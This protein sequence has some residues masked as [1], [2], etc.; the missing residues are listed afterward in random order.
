[1]VILLSGWS[2]QWGRGGDG[3]LAERNGQL[4]GDAGEMVILL[5]GWSAQWGRGGDGDLAE[6]MVSSVGTRGR[7]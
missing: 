4:S 3:D 5:S 1:M 6:R 2:A 7:W